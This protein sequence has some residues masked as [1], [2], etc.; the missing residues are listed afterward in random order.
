[1]ASPFSSIGD[2]ADIGLGFDA[3]LW[4]TDRTVGMLPVTGTPYHLALG[5]D[6]SVWFTEFND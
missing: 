6:H 3:N 2:I 4:M 1:L 5:S